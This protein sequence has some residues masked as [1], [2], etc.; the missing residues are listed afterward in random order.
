MLLKKV[1]GK[2]PTEKHAYKIPAKDFSKELNT[3]ILQINPLIVRENE[4]K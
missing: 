3:I 1:P 4:E 2:E